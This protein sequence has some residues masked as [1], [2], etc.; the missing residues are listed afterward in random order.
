MLFGGRPTLD[1]ALAGGDLIDKTTLYYAPYCGT[2][3]PIFNGTDLIATPFVSG[4][5]DQTGI[6]L[7]LAGATGGGS[8][9]SGV[10]TR[11][12]S[13][14]LART[15]AASN[16]KKWTFSAWV[17]RT[18]VGTVQRFFTVRTAN[19][20]NANLEILFFPDNS[21]G[22]VGWNTV[23]LKSTQAFTDTSGFYHVVVAVDT[24]A[25]DANQRLRL[26]VNGTELTSFA[27]RTNPGQGGLLAVNQ[28][29]A[30]RLGGADYGDYLDATVADV[31]LIDG[32][33]LTPAAFAANGAVIPYTGTYAGNSC[34]LD[35]ATIGA[36]VSGLGNTWTNVGVSQSTIVP[37]GLGGSPPPSA[38]LWA[39]DS[40]YDA[41]VIDGVEGAALC[42]SPAWVG[43]AR[44]AGIVR[45][46]GI[47]VNAADM[48]VRLNG[49]E[50]ALVPA[51]QATWV[52]TIR[53]NPNSVTLTKHESLGQDRR[54]GVWSPHNQEDIILRVLPPSPPGAVWNL[55][56]CGCQYPAWVPFNHDSANGADVLT[57]APTPVSVSYRQN[58]FLNSSGG[59]T[60]F[61][62]LVGWDGLPAGTYNTKSTDTNGITLGT[63]GP[64]EYTAVR[65]FGKHRATMLVGAANNLGGATLFG[66]GVASVTPAAAAS[67]D[68]DH[69]QMMLV[70]YRG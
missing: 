44:Q 41:F 62:G 37:P 5:L 43:N 70:R 63:G 38:G 54:C 49:G 28:G 33:Q 32:Q 12:Q 13:D 17:K 27:T 31:Y 16:R 30:H 26:Y 4:P 35:F 36:D 11:S 58:G 34:H 46:G 61:I 45:Y 57:G 60:A 64:A 67:I 18:S 14:V 10:W 22:V 48:T 51:H 20:D 21:L 55:G 29:A 56:S 6:S 1:P 69:N 66:A 9:A 25:L 7:T 8:G 39:P 65:A 52:A 50:E 42:T 53:T 15:F 23:F 3:L 19:T 68:N 59:P 2:T 47:P 24:D 40:I